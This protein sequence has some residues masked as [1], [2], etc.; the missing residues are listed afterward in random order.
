M[1]NIF[2]LFKKELTEAIRD[3]RTALLVIIFPLIFY[4]L[5]LGTIFNF[6]SSGVRREA[7]KS[8][9]VLYNGKGV[10]PTLERMIEDDPK[11]DPIFYENEKD[12]L[13]DFDTGRGD[14]VLSARKGT[15]SGLILDINHSR[16]NS[17][18]QLAL[19]RIKV[20][21]ENFLRK[22]TEG[23]LKDMGINPE[24][25][26][27][28]LQVN[29][30]SRGSEQSSI[31]KAFLERMLP[32]FIVL[33]IIT[34]A[35]SFGAEITA[36]EKEKKTIST[37]LSSQLTR[38]EIVLGKFL[39]VLA[40]ALVAALLGFIGLVYGLGIFGVEIS[41]SA[42]FRPIIILGLLLTLIPLTVILS[43][44]V[45][46]IG[47]FARNQKEAN[48]YQ[49]PIYM[50]IILTGIFSMTGSFQLNWVKFLIPIFNSLEI[51]KQLLLGQMNIQYLLLTF[52]SNFILGS[53]LI[54]F[55]IQLFKKESIV[56]RV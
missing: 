19:S 7:S 16:W 52:F 21:L 18:S 30:E 17:S 36:G 5:I 29:V 44:I 34:A 25:I 46:M 3:K 42:T 50:I 35:M 26:T 15:D 43:S 48:L 1:R 22:K 27:T 47:S 20:L 6:S 56:L 49:T 14:L 55:S 40:V 8:S 12:A 11:L 53:A 10:S 37:L 33:S 2:L 54:Y 9:I 45:M 41:L 13:E 4:P 24:K 32:Y 28:P 39:S 31:G 51:F 23:R 38:S